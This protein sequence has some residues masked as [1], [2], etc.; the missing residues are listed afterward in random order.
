MDITG[1][2]R[3]PASRERV[4]K[5]LGDPQV[6]KECIP[7]CESMKRE[8][9]REFFAVI[10]SRIGPVN[11]KFDSRIELSHLVAPE[12]YTISGEGRGGAAGFG[13]GVAE[14][15]LEGDGE[16]TVLHYRAELQV[17]GKLA[18]IGSRL[19][20]GATRKI[21]SDFF[22]RFAGLLS[23]AGCGEPV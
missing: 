22:S 3:I 4:W 20:A 1:E 15:R 2:F 21:V 5:A 7:G 17:G 6:L 9:E 8:S 12:A 10:R 11:A 23:G 14:V 18:Q 19:V 13:K 16:E